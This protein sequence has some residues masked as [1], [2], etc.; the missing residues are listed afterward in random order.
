[1]DSSLSSNILQAFAE[2]VLPPP[3]K[4]VGIH[5]INGSGLVNRWRVFEAVKNDPSFILNSQLGQDLLY[6]GSDAM[7]VYLPEMM[8]LFVDRPKACDDDALFFIV[9]V[10]ERAVGISKYHLP[11]RLSLKQTEAIES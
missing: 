10:L 11:I 8:R 5:G 7:R 3:N 9:E 6:M 2:N 1:M 4:M